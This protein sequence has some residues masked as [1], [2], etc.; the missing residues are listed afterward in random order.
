M[1]YHKEKAYIKVSQDYIEEVIREIST[2]VNKDKMKGIIGITVK[3][4]KVELFYRDSM[5]LYKTVLIPEK[6][7]VRGKCK[8]LIP[9]TTFIE[10]IGIRK[11]DHIE[12]SITKKYG[13]IMSGELGIRTEFVTQTM[14][15]DLIRRNIYI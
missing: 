8:A 4:E 11:D 12:I 9:Y 3:D 15:R 7:E 1:T 6:V 5:T 10:A 14:Y 2:A 13:Y